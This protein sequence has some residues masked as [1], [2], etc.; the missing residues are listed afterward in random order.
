ME[1]KEFENLGKKLQRLADENHIYS[2]KGLKPTP[3]QPTFAQLVAEGDALIEKE[4]KKSKKESSPPSET[5]KPTSLN[6][7]A[8]AREKVLAKMDEWHKKEILRMEAEGNKDNRF[9]DE[10]VR[11][12]R[13]LGDTLSS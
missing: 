13:E 12:V 10:F 11:K 1:K 7:Y 8:V 2:R 3:T 5:N 9:Y 6:P 4:S